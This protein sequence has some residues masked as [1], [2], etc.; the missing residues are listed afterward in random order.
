MSEEPA[1]PSS[2][3][4]GDAVVRTSGRLFCACGRRIR[5]FDFD[6]DVRSNLTLICDCGLELLNVEWLLR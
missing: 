6:L 4:V 3:T 5:P 1:R 2:F